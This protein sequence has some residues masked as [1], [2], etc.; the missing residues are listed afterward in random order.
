[1]RRKRPAGPSLNG[2]ALLDLEVQV[3]R[4]APVDQADPEALALLGGLRDVPGW[5][6][7]HAVPCIRPAPS[8]VDLV[9]A[10]VDPADRVHALG[11][12]RVLVSVRVRALV[13][14]RGWAEDL[15]VCC[16]RPKGLRPLGVQRAIPAVQAEARHGTRRTRK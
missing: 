2:P 9:V 7:A 1:M 15:A 14:D 6:P 10:R 3:G 4:E 11:L 5:L 16:R 8:R 12:G 13:P